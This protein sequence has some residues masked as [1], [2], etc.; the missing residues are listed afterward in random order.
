LKIK[1]YHM[2][3]RLQIV[4]QRFDEISV[5]SSAGCYFRRYVQLNQEYK[6]WKH[7]LKSAM[8]TWDH[9]NIEEANES[10]DNSD[11]DMTEMA[12]MQLDEAKEVTGGKKSNSCWSQRPRRR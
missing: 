4:K 6:L 11:A 5:W 8:N 10:Y 1:D 9:A 12:K 3:D 7:W 2:L